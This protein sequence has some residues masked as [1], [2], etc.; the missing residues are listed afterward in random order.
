MLGDVDNRF[1][2]MEEEIQLVAQVR[3]A[4]AENNTIDY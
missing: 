2:P 4:N 1:P 3:K